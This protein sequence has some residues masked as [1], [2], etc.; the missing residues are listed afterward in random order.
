M[1][2]QRDFVLVG[3]SFQCEMDKALLDAFH[4]VTD[5][6][7]IGESNWIIIN[8]NDE[9]LES[10]VGDIQKSL[11]AAEI[12]IGFDAARHLRHYF[13]NLGT[14]LTIN[15]VGMVHAYPVDT[16]CSPRI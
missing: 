11:P 13:S 14:N 3:M 5:D 9:A 4:H 10:V 1:I 15:L 6:L 8:P 12:Y 16:G 7:P 2:W